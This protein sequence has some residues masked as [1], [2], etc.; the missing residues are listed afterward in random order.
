MYDYTKIER[1]ERKKINAKERLANYNEIYEAYSD[2][3]AKGQSSRCIQ[4]GIPYCAS[5]GCPLNNNIPHWLKFNAE[6]NDEKAFQISNETSPFP[7]I[8]GKICPHN[9]LCEGACTLNDG[10][11][12]VTI[13]S[14]EVHINE[15]GF[16]N[17][18]KP[19][20]PKQLSD[21]KVAIIGSGPAGISC[22]NFLLR[23]GIKPVI[24]EKAD[25]PGGL[26][27]YGIPEFKLEKK[28]VFR[29]IQLLLEAGMELKL[30]TEVGKDISFEELRNEHD[31]VFMGFGA[32]EGRVLNHEG[33]NSE[34][35]Y[36]AVPF[37][38]NIQK[39]RLGKDF[40]LKY[41]VHGKNVVVIGGGDTAMDC[42]RTSIRSGAKSVKCVYRRDEENMPGS[43]KEVKAAKEEGI[44][45]IFTTAPKHFVAD[46]KGKIIGMKFVKT[47]IASDEK[48]PRG[49][50]VE[51]EN[52]EFIIEAD[53]IILAL[54]FNH[55]QIKF[56]NKAGIK[57]NTYGG[58]EV[59]ENYQTSL[60]GVYAG[61]DMVRGAD[62]AVN[63]AL[64]GREAAFK[65]S[66][67]IKNKIAV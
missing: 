67:Q 55:Q 29:R 44:E 26:L 56:L 63:A 57:A 19:S 1:L 53:I 54:G 25:E 59:D 48:S 17:G 42:V 46:E 27:L 15:K 35:V 43:D 61:G 34:H 30:N 47:K 28:D 65:I 9:R 14:I 49:K 3:T 8:L 32:T 39:K 60:T 18:L 41:N 7:E 31:A 12:A 66:A 24:F 52:S 22:A 5:S 51:V 58:I 36:M 64:D 62:L 16:E 10:H 38:T 37:L 33:Y 4:C 21:K 50:V 40:D 2:T 11:G 6:G 13:G 20:F 23:A 45:F